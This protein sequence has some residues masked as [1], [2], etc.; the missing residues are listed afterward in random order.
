M[1]AGR[2]A[3]VKGGLIWL[4]SIHRERSGGSIFQERAYFLVLKLSG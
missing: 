4:T 3:S 1:Q 2:Q